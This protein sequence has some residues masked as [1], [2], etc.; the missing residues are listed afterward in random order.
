[1]RDIVNAMKGLYESPGLKDLVNSYVCIK[2]P[3]FILG[4]ITL[5]LDGQFWIGKIESIDGFMNLSL[6]PPPSSSIE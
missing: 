5:P 2:N 3:K 1:M 4:S 6:S